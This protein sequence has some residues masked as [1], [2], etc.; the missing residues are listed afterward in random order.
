MTTL[1]VINGLDVASPCKASWNAMLGDERARFCGHCEKHVYNIAAMTSDDV[2][3]LIRRT[4]G[5]FC[6]RLYRRRDGT[7]L[8][9]DCP[10][11][12]RAFSSG[13]MHRVLTYGVLGLGFLTSGAFLKAA[14]DRSLSWPPTGPSVTFSDWR[15]WAWSVLGFS[16]RSGGFAGSRMVAGGICAPPA[17]PVS[18]T[19][20]VVPGS[21]PLS[22]QPVNDEDMSAPAP[23][24]EP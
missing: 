16:G 1:D 4:E 14:S 8:T 7:V 21:S 19:V 23:T 22:F 10:V 3:E 20:A 12:A 11:G 2:G 24:P 6:G 5:E 15:D 9:A 13:R 18:T 17:A